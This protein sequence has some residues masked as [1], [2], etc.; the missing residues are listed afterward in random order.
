MVGLV[1][2]LAACS[3]DRGA[4]A[5]TFV[6]KVVAG[7]PS[8]ADSL[9]APGQLASVA[10]RLGL[11][12][13]PGSV[14][15]AASRVVVEAA[16][17]EGD[18]TVVTFVLEAKLADRVIAT[19]NA[20]VS[21]PFVK[22]SEGDRLRAAAISASGGLPAPDPALLSKDG[23]SEADAQAMLTD[24]RAGGA[25]LGD[26]LSMSVRASTEPITLHPVTDL[27][28]TR[29]T[30][31]TEQTAQAVEGET[32]TWFIDVETLFDFQ[33]CLALCKASAVRNAKY[34]RVHGDGRFTECRVQDDVRR[35][36]GRGRSGQ[37]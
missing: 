21:L 35:F 23:T 31:Y 36:A 28:G 3:V 9:D 37:G 32:T 15:F 24:F 6:A 7:D 14:T 34:V 10:A 5:Q 27:D 1:V 16:K 25:W 29:L 2:A 30:T 12:G 13:W 18:P 20:T 4:M 19:S 26:A 22:T 17:G 8:A 33:G 11:T